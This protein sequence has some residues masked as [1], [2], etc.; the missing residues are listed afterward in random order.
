MPRNLYSEVTQRI[1][2][3]LEAGTPPWVREW[4]AIGRGNVPMN[5]I[6][7]RPYSG[8]NVIM[9]WMRGYPTHRYLTFKQALDSGG[10]VRKGDHGTRV[11]YVSQMARTSDTTDEVKHIPFLKEYTIFNTAQRVGLPDTCF[12]GDAPAINQDQRDA[13]AQA[14]IAVT[15]AD[16]RE[17]MG[18]AYYAPGA[19]FISMPHFDAFK[20]SDGFYATGFHELSHNADIRIMPRGLK[21]PF[22]R[23]PEAT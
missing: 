9:L 8:C 10:H 7:R 14:L 16:F 4:K 12:G 20:D 15:G 11:Y 22:G 3:Q 1:V 21:S 6:T 17:G 19:D 18:E 23:V 2:A 5:A 13:E